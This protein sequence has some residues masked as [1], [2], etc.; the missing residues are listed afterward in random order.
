MTSNLIGV[1]AYDKYGNLMYSVDEYGNVQGSNYGDGVDIYAPGVNILSTVSTPTTE[2]GYILKSGTSMAAPYVTGVAALLLSVDPTLNGSQLK[3]LILNN[4][5]EMTLK[6]PR[7]TETV[8]KLN[9]G[10]AVAQ[11]ERFGAGSGTPSDP[12]LISTEAQFRNIENTCTDVYVPGSGTEKQ[13]TGSFK[14]MKDITLSGDWM[15][16]PYRFSGDFDGNGHS[17]TYN[18]TLTQSDINANEYQ[19][20]FGFVVS[21][22]KIHDLTLNNC[23]ITSDTGTT[24]SRSDYVNIGIV[25]GSCYEAYALSNV[26]VNNPKIECKISN[27]YIGGLAGSLS[28]GVAENCTVGPSRDAASITNNA[29]YSYIG[30]LAGY[31]NSLE[32][33]R[34]CSVR[35][36]LTNT[37]F[38]GDTDAMGKVISNSNENPGDYNITEDVNIVQGGSCLAEGTLVTLA[39]GTQKAVEELTKGEEL[40]V[41]NFVTGQL[42]TAPI[43]FVDSEPACVTEVVALLFS[44]G[45]EVRVIGEHG[46]WDYT[47]NRYV[48]LDAQAEDYV[49]HSFAYLNGDTLSRVTLESVTIGNEYTVAYSPVTYSHLCYYV[50]GMLSMPG[51]IEGLFN[52]FD[53]DADTMRYDEVAMQEDIQTYGQYTYEEF[54]ELVPVSEEVFEAFN[55]QYLKVAIGKGLID[56]DRLNDLAARYAKFFA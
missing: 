34:G 26:T 38:N 39:D 22:G 7:G 16:L 45:T 43:L 37:A 54:S 14:L 23:S 29:N 20:L 10:K 52:I 36:T 15:A 17:I 25:A 55:G 40:L 8:L 44:D 31:G 56:L 30:G 42:D 27:A 13:I 35:I 3:T 9:A 4:A 46:F 21:G 1:G 49:G 48:Y 6:T 28:Y 51:G 11:L 5:D 33:F 47:L 12:Y 41:W 19:G 53:V 24:L 18:M 2:Q 50:N 32:Q